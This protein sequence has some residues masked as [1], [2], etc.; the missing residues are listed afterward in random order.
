M[1]VGPGGEERTLAEYEAL[2]GGAGLSVTRVVPTDRDIS[3]IEA[4]PR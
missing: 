3:V 1:L 2:L 4:R